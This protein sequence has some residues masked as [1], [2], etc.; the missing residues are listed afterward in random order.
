[1]GF[2]D[3]L[4]S[5]DTNSDLRGAYSEFSEESYKASFSSFGEISGAEAEYCLAFHYLNGRG[6]SRDPKKAFGLFVKSMEGGY[7]PA[8]S[9]VGQCYGYGIGTK[10]D[11]EKAFECFTRASEAGDPYGMSMVSVMFE[12]GD[13]VKRD[14]R[15]AKEWSE[16]CEEAGDLERIEAQGIYYL[17]DGNLILARIWLMRSAVMGSPISAKILECM[18]RHGVGVAADDDEASDWEDTADCEG[19]DEVARTDILD[20]EEWL[21]RYIEVESLPEE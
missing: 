11:D 13:G 2:F 20:C 3:S 12:N 21:S 5:A 18:Y 14:P 17:N 16:R 19:W 7:L 4:T 15:K 9:E 10:M 8:I 6:T 1:M